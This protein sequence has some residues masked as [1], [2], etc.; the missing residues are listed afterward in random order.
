MKIKTKRLLVFGLPLIG[1][2]Y[3]G[4]QYYKY[5]ELNQFLRSYVD[6]EEQLLVTNSID[7]YVSKYGRFPFKN[8]E[9]YNLFIQK[10]KKETGLKTN[11]FFE[12]YPYG[13]AVDSASL[14]YTFYSFG[15]DRNFDD[16]EYTP[17]NNDT[18]L[19]S[20]S[21]KKVDFYS[22]LFLNKNFDIVLNQ[23]NLGK[24]DCNKHKSEIFSIL[25]KENFDKSKQLIE[26]FFDDVKKAS[27]EF[28]ESL[29]KDEDKIESVGCPIFV[30]KDNRIVCLCEGGADTN[31]INQIKDSLINKLSPHYLSNIEIATFYI[32]L[33]R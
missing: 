4:Y 26:G 7:F 2:I 25:L 5:H 17:F 24:Y 21:P 28:K 23:R 29:N 18:D 8:S 14:N 13:I 30:Y 33:K 9:E 16:L 3:L 11:F 32:D 27:T 19:W 20:F 12:E 22:Y 31:T 10:L 6:T 15:P 1:F